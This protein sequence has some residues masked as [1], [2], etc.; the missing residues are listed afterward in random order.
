MVIGFERR[1]PEGLS[2]SCKGIHLRSLKFSLILTF[3]S[4]SNLLGWKHNGWLHVVAVKLQI[5][6]NKHLIVRVTRPLAASAYLVP[7][8]IHE[9]AASRVYRIELQCG[10]EK[11]E[12]H[13]RRR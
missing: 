8:C 5:V 3:S 13:C 10:S 6:V 11:E 2:D 12:C 9:Q 4:K 7:H 1:P